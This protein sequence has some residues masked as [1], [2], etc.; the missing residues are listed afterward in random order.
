MTFSFFFYQH[1]A[2]RYVYT[3]EYDKNTGQHK[4]QVLHY[5]ANEY[6]YDV[7]FS[8]FRLKHFTGKQVYSEVNKKAQPYKGIDVV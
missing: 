4:S 2:Q 1:R 8:I 3:N 7:N 6:G 5:P